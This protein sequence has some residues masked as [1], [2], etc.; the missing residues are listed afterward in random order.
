MVAEAIHS[1]SGEDQV[2]FSLIFS[3]L[4]SRL[5]GKRRTFC[6]YAQ[7]LNSAGAS[8][9]LGLS[10]T[11]CMMTRARQP[12][13]HSTLQGSRRNLAIG[14]PSTQMAKFSWNNQ[15]YTMERARCFRWE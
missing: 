5:H 11:R 13:L 2:R 12:D 14:V 9:V 8:H 10:R 4:S 6:A 7:W 3:K 1:K 15:A